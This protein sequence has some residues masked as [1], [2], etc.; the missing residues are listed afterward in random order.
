PKR[1]NGGRVISPQVSPNETTVW[2]GPDT[3]EKITG[4]W[5]MGGHYPDLN[6]PQTPPGIEQRVISRN[7][8]KGLR[9]QRIA[10]RT[11]GIN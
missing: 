10:D 5:G 3:R 11:L 1:D 9:A 6:Y 7:N 2:Y 8:W 4:R